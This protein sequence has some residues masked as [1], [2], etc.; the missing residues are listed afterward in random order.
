[1]KPVNSVLRVWVLLC[2]RCK[3]AISALLSVLVLAGCSSTPV[4]SYENYIMN[5]PSLVGVKRLVAEG[6]GINQVYF[7][8]TPLCM[9]ARKGDIPTMKYLI[10]LGADLNLGNRLDSDFISP[11]HAAAAVG[12]DEAVKLLLIHGADT[13]LKNE[14]GK[15]PLMIARDKRYWDVEQAGYDR[16][17]A[18]F[19]AFEHIKPA[20][21][22]ATQEDTE[23]SYTAFIEQ[24][25][26]TILQEVAIEKRKAAMLRDSAPSP[27]EPRLATMT[28]SNDAPAIQPESVEPAAQTK[29][30]APNK[31]NKVDAG[32]TQPAEVVKEEH[33]VEA[34]DKASATSSPDRR[35]LVEKEKFA[36][37]K[38]YNVGTKTTAGCINVRLVSNDEA[39]S[40]P[41]DSSC[42]DS[43]Q[44]L[45]QA[46]G[47]QLGIPFD[48]FSSGL[49]TFESVDAC[50]A[51]CDKSYGKAWAQYGRKCLGLVS[52]F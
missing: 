5:N 23:A 22:E 52:S 3:L 25:P 12:K 40:G 1:M 2:V 29:I 11:L 14:S 28:Q 35:L 48:E 38:T 27:Q 42:S 6:K 47:K 50:V 32:M 44:G 7:H 4:N 20:W 24:N 33:A 36:V 16:T 10:S 31:D 49:G 8:G 19:E 17:I 9:A 34:D 39:C 37:C 18:I 43:M 46:V 21:D 30:V 51:A 15:T 45:C 13:S 26:N 41:G